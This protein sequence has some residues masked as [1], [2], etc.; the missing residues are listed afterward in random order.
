M[1]NHV[2]FNIPLQFSA[3][4]YIHVYVVYILLIFYIDGNL[5]VP[6]IINPVYTTNNQNVPN[7]EREIQRQQQQSNHQC[8]TSCN[9]N[10]VVCSVPSIDPTDVKNVSL[11]VNGACVTVSSTDDDSESDRYTTLTDI[12]AKL[13]EIDRTGARHSFD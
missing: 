10:E 3:M 5:P 1:F 12:Q 7:L 13:D 9:E 11:P 8:A 2:L 6:G 4:L